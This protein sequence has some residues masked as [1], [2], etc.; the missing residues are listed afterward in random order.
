MEF[1][2]SLFNVRKIAPG[3]ILVVKCY[4]GNDEDHSLEV[5]GM[6][7]RIW[8]IKTTYVRWFRGTRGNDVFVRGYFFSNNGMSVEQPLSLQSLQDATS[9]H[10][11]YI[12]DVYEEDENPLVLSRHNIRNI[13]R[14][15]QRLH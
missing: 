9:F 10:E 13:K 14:R 12:L 6:Y 7:E 2:R 3:D 4:L 8:V 15:L 1:P 5:P 11:S